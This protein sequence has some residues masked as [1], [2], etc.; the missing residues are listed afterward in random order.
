MAS[1]RDT[2]KRMWMNVRVAGGGLSQAALTFSLAEFSYARTY[3]RAA[4]SAVAFL[5]LH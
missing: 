1:S 4:A 5:L 3:L 2:Q